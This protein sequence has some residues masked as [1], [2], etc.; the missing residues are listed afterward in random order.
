MSGTAPKNSGASYQ[1][2]G[3]KQECASAPYFDP[4]P[5]SGADSAGIRLAFWVHW[6]LLH[7]CQPERGAMSVLRLAIP[8]PLRRLFDYLP[9]EGMS[10]AE[11]AALSPGQRLSVPFG[12]RNVTA[13]NVTIAGSGSLCLLDSDMHRH[14]NIH[15]TLGQGAKSS[16]DRFNGREEE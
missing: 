9:P 7:R 11:V 2:W 8:S 6:V 3:Q 14:G 12:T 13:F 16:F 4:E 10:E 5:R 15:H 1:T